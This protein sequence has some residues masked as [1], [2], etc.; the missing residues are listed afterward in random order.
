MRKKLYLFSLL[1]LGSTFLKAATYNGSCG[2][3]LTWTLNTTTGVLEISGTGAMDNWEDWYDVPW[4][5]YMSSIT[6]LII[7]EGVT[8]I[9]DYA[10]YPYD[11]TSALSSI[12]IPNS[13]TRIGER[14]FSG[15]GFLSS[16]T[17]HN[18]ITSIGTEAFSACRSLTSITIPN[19]VTYMGQYVFS[20]CTGLTSITIDNNRIESYSFAYCSNLK[21]VYIG[22]SL[23]WIGDYAFYNCSQL[24]D[25]Y[26]ETAT[27]SGLSSTAFNNSSSNIIVYVPQSSVT[28]Y[29][30]AIRW[31]NFTIVGG[32]GTCGTN[33]TWTLRNHILT[34]SGSGAMANWTS[35]NRAP[36][37]SQ[38]I[39][40]VVINSGIT[41]IGDWAFDNCRKLSLI[42]IPNSVTSIGDDAFFT[43]D[44]LKTISIPNSVTSIG[45]QAF[46]C[47]G[48]RSI[49]IP[50]SVTTLGSWAFQ[51]CYYL[52]T[53]TIGNG[54]TDIN[55]LTF[56]SCSTLSSIT[57]GNGVTNIHGQAFRHC[58]LLK[59]IVIPDNVASIGWE[60]FDD[61]SRLNTI[62]LGSGVTN[63]EIAFT[64]CSALSDIFCYTNPAELTWIWPSYGFKDNKATICHVYDAEAWLTAFP[65]ANVTFVGDLSVTGLCGNNVTWYFNTGTGAL[66]ISGTGEMDNLTVWTDEP[67]YS[68]RSSITSVVINSG[69]KSIGSFAFSQCSNFSSIS[70][71]NTVKSIGNSAFSNCSGLN[72]ITIG[73][74]VTSI[75]QG[76][77]SACTSLSTLYIPDNVTS[78][79]G[80]SFLS[81]SGIKSVTI[82]NGVTTIKSYTFAGCSNLTS[83]IIGSGVTSIGHNAFDYCNSLTSIEIPSNVTNIEDDAF[84][85]CS[86]LKTV[87]INSD[88]ILNPSSHHDPYYI[89]GYQVLTY[90]LGDNVT[91]ICN[92]AFSNCGSMTSIT[93]P[94]SVTSIGE[95][96]FSGCFNLTK[97]NISDIAAWCAVSFANNISNPLYYA[98][99]LYLNESEVTD[100]II[101]EGVTSIGAY[102][103][104]RCSGLSSIIIPNSVTSIGLQAF[105]NCSSISS[106]TSYAVTPP[107]TKSSTFSSVPSSAILYVLNESMS[108]YENAANWSGFTDMRPIGKTL[109]IGATGWA[110]FS[111][112]EP[113][114]LA[115]ISASTGDAVAYY[116]SDASGSTVTLTETAAS[117]PAGE[118]ILVKGTNGATVTIP[119]ASSGTTISGNKLVGCPNGVT[120]TPSTPDYESI[121]VLA[122]NNGTA[123]F[124]NVKDYVDAHASL[125]IGEEKAY[126]NLAD[127][128]L[129]PGALRIIFDENHATDIHVLE[130]NDCTTKFFENG[131]L[132]IM[133][134]GAV[135]DAT[136]RMIR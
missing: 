133:R 82:G 48:L 15:C 103:F 98:H 114:D 33:L 100:L 64:N 125:T 12:V 128:T 63:L 113:L 34:I 73:N 87:V 105:Y 29:Q 32:S 16:V 11:K 17:I 7:N 71:P 121:Y 91:S 60:A 38:Y 39:T 28:A 4:E 57:I 129:A 18:G 88:H 75:G 23:S 43:C 37:P 134:E 131:Q 136:G 68:Q 69:V 13:V 55:E 27:P 92:R 74:G 42:S 86:N 31:R 106:I 94:N 83:V 123:E 6:S 76:A 109:S 102:A 117:V 14:A 67:W 97:V 120:I 25:L 52:S 1:L 116:A 85:E 44:S 3:N 95:N 5:R 58:P 130:A 49:K 127:V 84:S 135:Y 124:Q 40:S 111:C 22:S 112:G 110:T 72:S 96:A 132:R 2:T 35:D 8:S 119:V 118:G 126:L 36:W 47:S 104:E 101:P 81:G 46:S 65:D 24:E 108:D 21:S 115:N 51:Y 122:N 77:F 9:G 66:T 56:S 89:F 30:N 54:V 80:N 53:V 45:H 99:H 70:I 20:G 61:C 26:I 93:I 19:S 62:T 50:D 78:I 90:I 59:S 10:F 79:G 41:S 107:T